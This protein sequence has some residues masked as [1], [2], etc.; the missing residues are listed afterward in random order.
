MK[1][2]LFPYSDVDILVLMSDE[3]NKSDKRKL[4]IHHSSMILDSKLCHVRQTAN[5]FMKKDVTVCTNLIEARR[6]W[7]NEENISKLKKISINQIQK[8][9]LI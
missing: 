7:G 6:L 8:N 1:S 3:I 5:A 4:K 9:S 2:K